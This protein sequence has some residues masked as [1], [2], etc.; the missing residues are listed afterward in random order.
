MTAALVAGME[1]GLTAST[2]ASAGRV[3]HANAARVQRPR[4]RDGCN[5]ASLALGYTG[6]ATLG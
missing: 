6:R 1:L 2:G 5:R 4:N 3:H